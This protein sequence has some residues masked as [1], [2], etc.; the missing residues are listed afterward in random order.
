[1]FFRLRMVASVYNPNSWKAEAEG[2]QAQVRLLHS[3]IAV[4]LS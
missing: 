1:M 4:S 3:E 2:L